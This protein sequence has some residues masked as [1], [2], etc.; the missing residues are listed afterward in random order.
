MLRRSLLLMAGAR[1]RQSDT[2]CVGLLKKSSSCSDKPIHPMFIKKEGSISSNSLLSSESEL[3]RIDSDVSMTTTASSLTEEAS[4]SDLD[5]SE[6]DLE[7]LIDNSVAELW[8]QLTDSGWK[9][10]LSEEKDKDYFRDLAYFV[11]KERKSKKVFPQSEDVFTAFNTTPYDSIKVIIIGQDP[12]HGDGQAHGLCFSVMPGVKTPPSLRNIYKELVQDVE[13]FETP[14]HGYLLPWAE[15]GILM[16]N[17]TLTVQAHKA[18]SHAKSGWQKFTDAAILKLSESK[19]DLLFLLW[20]GFA[21]KKGKHI[22]RD[23]HSV[24]ETFHP[25]PLSV[26]K[27]RNCRVFSRA[28]KK[29]IKLGKDPINWRLSKD[30]TKRHKRTK[31]QLLYDQQEDDSEITS[32]DEETSSATSSSR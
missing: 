11:Q 26:T 28:N 15:Q 8:N 31:A 16:L 21:H 17:A 18:N 27:W 22:C 3:G 12:Y 24:I 1:K 4:S 25:S 2:K 7:K 5:L 14:E 23:S 10:A 20:G 29:L 13:G 9:E 32:E 19:K 6:E 30:P